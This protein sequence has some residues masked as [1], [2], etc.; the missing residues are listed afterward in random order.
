MNP[1]LFIAVLLLAVGLRLPSPHDKDEWG[2]RVHNFS[3]RGP[4]LAGELIDR[5][6][7]DVTLINF[8]KE[9]RAH[10]YLVVAK[11]SGALQVRICD[12][13]G[14]EVSR[15][16]GHKEI[17][18]P[19]AEQ[20]KLRPAEQ[21][22]ESFSFIEF[23]YFVL[24]LGK[25][26]MEATL[27][28]D[29]K[30]LTSPPVELEVVAVP[31]SAV[32][33]NYW[34]PIEGVLAEQPPEDRE[35]RAIQQVK[36]G[37]RTYLIFRR[38]HSPKNGGKPSY[39]KRLAELPG[40]VELKVEGAAGAGR[41]LTVTYPDTNSPIQ[42]AKLVINSN[43]GRPWTEEDEKALREREKPAPPAKP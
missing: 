27:K 41:P 36:V 13:D 21:R 17:F 35:L 7:F 16:V 33:V 39:V 32:L 14:K 2:L 38:Y 12:P 26:Q 4:Y 5:S 24:G 40:K 3:V 28:I 1:T 31:E 6:R 29:G 10:D 15:F 23:G 18:K 37:N 34:L 25:H 19:F 22:T 9:R 11:R 20:N 42:L 43:S 8:S 30:T